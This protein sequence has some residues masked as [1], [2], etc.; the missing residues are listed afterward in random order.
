MRYAHSRQEFIDL[1]RSEGYDV[2][3]TD[4]RRSITYTTPTGMK[5]RDDRLHGEKYSKE[6]ME[7]EFR[8]REE[9][10]HGGVE[11]AEYIFDRANAGTGCG[12]TDAAHHCD[13][14]SDVGGAGKAGAAPGK[15]GAAHESAGGSDAAIYGSQ[16]AV[17]ESGTDAADPGAA[18]EDRGTA[19][20]GWEEE[21]AAL[22]SALDPSAPAHAGMATAPGGATGIADAVVQLGRAL[23]RPGY[24][25]PVKEATAAHHHADS[26]TLRKERQKKIALG[27]KEDDHEDEQ[28]WQQ[29]M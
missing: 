19:G 6:M 5:C 26:K 28:T 16:N 10:I 12:G 3:W 29:T 18:S 22:F 11:A 7:R 1:M 9:I 25:V 20:T 17:S 21:R 2:K 14:V 4:N 27:H 24:A 8:I 13:P 23:E 15:S